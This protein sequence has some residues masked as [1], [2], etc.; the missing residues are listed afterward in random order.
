MLFRSGKDRL[1]MGM[2]WFVV[3]YFGSGFLSILVC[4]AALGVSGNI[5]QILAE[6]MSQ[7]AFVTLLV[8]AVVCYVIYTVI[9]CLVCSRLFCKGVNLD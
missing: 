8:C 9:N 2:I 7:G 3:Y 4:V 6:Q 5:A 1:T